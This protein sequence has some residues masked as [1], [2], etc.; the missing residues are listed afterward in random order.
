MSDQETA[1]ISIQAAMTGH[2]V[3]STLHTNDAVSAIPRML[4]LG[5]PDYLVAATLEG[6]LA[7]RLV[8]RICDQCREQ[9]EPSAEV[10]SAVSGRP[11]RR[12]T[13]WRGTGCPACR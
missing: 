1:E 2:L 7:Q 3:F 12:A 5:I 4:D 9:Y 10:V 11:V 8:R 6:V 13:L